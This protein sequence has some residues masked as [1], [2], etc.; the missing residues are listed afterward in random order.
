MATRKKPPA[1]GSRQL[2][3][4]APAEVPSRTL[5]E[6]VE[7][8]FL[9]YSMSV[10]V[11]RALPDVRDGLKPVQRR[12]LWAMHDA[13]LRPDR[14]FV[15]CARVVGDVMANYHPHGDTAIYDALVRM[16]QSFSLTAILVD[17]HGNFG[18]PSDPPA[19]SRYT[20]C[21]LSQVAM[22]MLAGIDEGTVDFEPNYDGSRTEPVVVPARFPNLLVNGSQGI[23]G[24]MAI[25]TPPHNLLEVCNAAIRLIDKPDVTLSELMRHVKGP[26]FPTGG[27]IM[28]D[29]GIK[30]AYRTGR[31]TVRVRAVHEIEQGKRGGQAII[32]TEIPF[33]TSIDTI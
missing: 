6:E 7:A 29:D 9:E 12:I 4:D 31:G 22:E 15:K 19:A 24:G 28:G 20:E 2:T 23:A 1:R 16:G 17:K 14:P 30:D 10:I 32:L 5:V 13:N 3:L 8:A 27:L 11:S 25:S 26:D 21:R 33:Q 18:S